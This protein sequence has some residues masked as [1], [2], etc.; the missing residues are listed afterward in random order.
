MNLDL[1]D[2][3]RPRRLS[4]RVPAIAAVAAV[5]LLTISPVVVVAFGLPSAGAPKMLAAANPPVGQVG[6][7]AATDTPTAAPTDTP[8]AA[9]TDTPT[10]PLP[11]P[12]PPLP[13][14]TPPLPTP[15]PP[16]PTPTPPLATPT[17]P[18]ATPTPPLPTPTPPLFP[19]PPVLPTSPLFPTPV[20]PITQPPTSGP[21]LAPRPAPLPKPLLVAGLATK[22]SLE[23]PSGSPIGQN[24]TV[25]AT[26]VDQ[27]G[28]PLA[29][30]HLDLF[31]D[32]QQ[33]RS[34][35]TDIHGQISFAI[36]GNRLDTARTYSVG[37]LFSGAHGLAGSTATAT[38]TIL[39]AS[40]QIHTVPPLPNIRFTLGTASALTGPDGLAALPVPAKGTYQLT[41]DLNSNT[42]NETVRAS[43]VRWLDNV[44]TSARTIDVTG[45]A[46]YTMG[47]RVAYRATIQYVDLTDQPVDPSLVEQAQF[48][49]GTGSGD[50]VINSQTKA[51]DVWW[52]AATTIRVG[53][54]LVATP[55]TYRVIS[56][57]IH[58]AETV[59][60]GQQSWTPSQ[61]GAWNI[62]LLLY[63]MTVRTSDAI[64]GSPVSGQIQLT[65]PDGHVTSAPIGGD[66]VATF[67]SLPRGQY[68]LHL[69]TS[70]FT[71]PTP[72]ALSKPQSAVLRVI[73]T[74]DILV[75]V[76]L[77]VLALGMLGAIGRVLAYRGALHRAKAR[78]AQE[79]SRPLS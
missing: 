71:P 41:T 34:D 13:T 6:A 40:I 21:T 79:S 73:T 2:T 77:V 70:T 27:S 76:G 39:S 54:S 4:G 36:L 60:R 1:T 16:L 53:T 46:S 59:N 55:I 62:T 52:T 25:V 20:V 68:Q 57:K 74:M 3:R 64:F 35:K 10:P 8:T 30:Q 12:T 50:V 69:S 56:V 5:I 65:Y 75:G 42:P 7:A 31:L 18:L 47:L 9:P 32:G 15:T 58:G 49:T 17:P 26:L 24:V 63:N 51:S 67:G 37:L 45:P 23:V 33:I 19:T 29:G 44:Y 38:L 14:P 61:N 11:T 28:N 72:V 22:A 66:G 48:S 43:F 78:A